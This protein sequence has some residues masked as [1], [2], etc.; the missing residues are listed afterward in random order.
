[1]KNTQQGDIYTLGEHII[2]CGDSLDTAFVS[3]VIGDKKIRAITTDPPYAVAY[4]EGKRDLN[5]LKEWI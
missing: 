1:M 4:V 2:A 5:K 3:R